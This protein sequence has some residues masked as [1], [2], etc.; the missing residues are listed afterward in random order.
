[1]STQVAL[2]VKNPRRRHKRCGFNHWVGKIPWRRKWQSP[3]VFLP[4]ESL[5]REAWWATVHSVTKSWTQLKQLSIQNHKRFNFN[6]MFAEFA[7]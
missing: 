7:R 2:E 1:M 5:D 6:K 3:P 4:G